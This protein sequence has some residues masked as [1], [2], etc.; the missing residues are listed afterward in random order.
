MT[1]ND[2]VPECRQARRGGVGPMAQN[3]PVPE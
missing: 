1:Q 3:D 2:P